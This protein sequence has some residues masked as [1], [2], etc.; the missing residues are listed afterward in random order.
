M[1]FFLLLLFGIKERIT[2]LNLLIVVR[3]Y[4]FHN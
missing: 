1:W 2:S 3:S 4:L